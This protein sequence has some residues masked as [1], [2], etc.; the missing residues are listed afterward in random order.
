MTELGVVGR[1]Q[2]RL[3]GTVTFDETP[4][5][6]LLQ[7]DFQAADGAVTIDLAGLERADSVALA[8]LLAWERAVRA[9]GQALRLSHIPPRLKDLMQ[10]SGLLPLFAAA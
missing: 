6:A 8:L 4:S 2:Y 9:R 5:D 3:T 1:G 7:P 10:V